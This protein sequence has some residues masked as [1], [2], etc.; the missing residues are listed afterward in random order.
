MARANRCPSQRFLL[1]GTWVIHVSR[2]SLGREW[3]ESPEHPHDHEYDQQLE[4]RQ[5]FADV[6]STPSGRRAYTAC[7]NAAAMK[8][9]SD[10]KRRIIEGSRRLM[11]SRM[12][13]SASAP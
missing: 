6:H 8:A 11:K 4:Q 10:A 3:H 2:D 1:P 13:R 7:N 9:I 5:P 12:R